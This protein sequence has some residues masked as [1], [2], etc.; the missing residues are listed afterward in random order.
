M[1]KLFCISSIAL[2]LAACGGNTSSTIGAGSTLPD[3]KDGNSILLPNEGDGNSSVSDSILPPDYVYLAKSEPFS[4]IFG[5][6]SEHVL[7]RFDIQ[8][9]AFKIYVPFPILTQLDVSGEVPGHPE[10]TFYSDEDN[11]G[12]RSL[13]L[14]IPLDKYLDLLD[15]STTLPDGR[16][17]PNVPGGDLP[18][19]GFE[20]PDTSLNTAVYLGKDYLA[21]FVESDLNLRWVTDFNVLKSILNSERVKIGSFGWI[22]KKNG[23]KGGAFVSLRLPR[24]LVAY[25]GS[26]Q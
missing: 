3:Q 16:P 19:L 4:S 24:E 20:L 5:V 1:K 21:F 25:I 18:L 2:A 23:Y 10:I 26:L 6:H 15:S 12:K 7:L 9:R 14:E 22:A 13:V 8:T 11:K 17:L